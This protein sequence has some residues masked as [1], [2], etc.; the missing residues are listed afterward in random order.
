MKMVNFYNKEQHNIVKGIY[1][2]SRD[3]DVNVQ[4]RDKDDNVVTVKR[5][6]VF[7]FF[8]IFLKILN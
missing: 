3:V 8:C 5:R 1:T 6:L 4:V 2:T 7:N